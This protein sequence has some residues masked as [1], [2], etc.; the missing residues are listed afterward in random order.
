MKKILLFGEPMALLTTT[1]YDSLDEAEMF[2]KTLA[3]A[4]VNVAIGL[5][6]LGHQATYL[7][8]LGDDPWGHYIKKKLYQEGIDTRLVYYN[9]LFPTGM[10]MKNQVIEGDPDIYYY[11]QGSAF[12][13][14]DTNLIDQ[15]NLNDFDQLHIT[16]IPLALSSKTRETSLRL[17]KK[18]REAGLYIS[19]DPNLRPSLWPNQTTMIDTTNEMAKY[20]NMFLPGNNEGK[21]LM[22]SDDPEKIAVYYHQLG[23]DEL[24]IKLGSQGA[25]YSSKNETLTVPGFN[26]KKVIDTVGAG[27]G[28]AAGIISGHLEA[29]C[30]KDML[31]RANAI[32][33]IQVQ[34]LGDNEGLPNIEELNAYLKKSNCEANPESWIEPTFGVFIIAKPT[35]EQKIGIYIKQ[36]QGIL[37]ISLSK[38]YKLG[39]H[40]VHDLKKFH[41]YEGLK[42]SI[43]SYINF[44]NNKS[45]KNDSKI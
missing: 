17:V 5:T 21:I 28:F 31:I 27:D 35:T 18:A 25:Y 24:V 7:T 29:L 38:G 14:I 44:Y 16:G 43:N 8:V 30:S 22:G 15:I 42:E 26:V 12:S 23:C 20:C 9:S 37:L 4:E 11:R 19:F 34:T 2:K 41:V 39:K 6:R 32:G 36:I 1:S 33:A 40:N 13:N 45:Y 10:M 3:G